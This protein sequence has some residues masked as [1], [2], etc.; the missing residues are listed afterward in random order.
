MINEKEFIQFDQLKNLTNDEL[1]KEYYHL[2]HIFENIKKDMDLLND[3]MMDIKHTLK[4]R[5]INY[6]KVEIYNKY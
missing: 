1:E 6:V 2:K 5:N 4:N 3:K